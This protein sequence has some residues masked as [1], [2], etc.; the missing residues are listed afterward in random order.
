[1]FLKSGSDLLFSKCHS[2]SVAQ[3][4]NHIRSK[5]EF[6]QCLKPSLDIGRKY[7]LLCRKDIAPE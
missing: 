4:K 6:F 7:D 5:T 3:N 1:M 2:Y